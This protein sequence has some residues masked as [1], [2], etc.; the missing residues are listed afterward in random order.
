MR[1]GTYPPGPN[2]SFMPGLEAAGVVAAVGKGG[3]APG[4]G[5]RAAV[6]PPLPAPPSPDGAPVTRVRESGQMTDVAGGDH[7]RGPR[8]APRIRAQQNGLRAENHVGI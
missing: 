8:L 5:M 1:E 4:I 3:T 7:D 2:P 6:E